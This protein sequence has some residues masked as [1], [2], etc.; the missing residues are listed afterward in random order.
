MSSD[1]DNEREQEENN[2]LPTQETHDTWIYAYRKQGTYPEYH[3]ERSGKW[4]IFLS[5][6]TVDR[7]WLRI[8]EAV[9]QGQL[10]EQAKV[11]TAQALSNGRSIHA[12]C[13]YTYDYEDRDDVMRI[14]E[15][16]RT[17]GVRRKIVYKADE[18]TL[19]GRYGRD[20]EPKYR[21]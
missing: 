4:L 6:A 21:A 15:V 11:S 16:L 7:Y 2:N 20:Y 9:E 1:I 19:Q 17:L 3:P 5:P 10:G 8:K 18:D 14:R 12:I 13:V